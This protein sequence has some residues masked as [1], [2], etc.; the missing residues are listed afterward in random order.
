M[1]EQVKKSMS[2]GQLQW[3]EKC[4]IY[5]YMD[6]GFCCSAFYGTTCDNEDPKLFVWS[7]VRESL[8]T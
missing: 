2:V 6:P 7:S 5:I 4:K 3:Y 1:C 8:M